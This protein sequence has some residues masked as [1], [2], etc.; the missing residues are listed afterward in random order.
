MNERLFNSYYIC[1]A[2]KPLSA[3]GPREAA[4]AWDDDA[5]FD[6]AH[7]IAAE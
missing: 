3:G 1:R 5:E 7:R 2:M 6:E 4:Q